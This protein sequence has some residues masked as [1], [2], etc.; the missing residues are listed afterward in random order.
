MQ[1]LLFSCYSLPV[2]SPR[3]LAHPSFLI[4]PIAPLRLHQLM[5]LLPS[6]SWRRSV[7]CLTLL[8]FSVDFHRRTPVVIASTTDGASDLYSF[9]QDLHFLRD[10]ASDADASLDNGRAEAAPL[11]HRDEISPSLSSSSSS[12]PSSSLLSSLLLPREASEG[13]TPA[14]LKALANSGF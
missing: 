6:L 10:C 7:V 9:L 14:R 11:Q 2:S 5:V 13:R 12:D 8:V 4:T 3:V 1:H